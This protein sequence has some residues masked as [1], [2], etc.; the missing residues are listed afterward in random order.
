MRRWFTSGVG[1]GVGEGVGVGVSVAVGSGDAVDV[2]VLVGV[3]VLVGVGEGV[4]VIGVS[5][6][7][8]S[9][10]GV[11][12]DSGPLPSQATNNMDKTMHENNATI[13]FIFPSLI[14][15][16]YGIGCFT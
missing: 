7:T 6:I 16:Y 9:V 13:V 11:G 5:S 4:S 1:K 14:M 8:I 10:M 15:C 2:G 3:S 12:V